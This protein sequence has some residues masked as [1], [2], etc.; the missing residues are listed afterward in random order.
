[1]HDDSSPQ[2]S[3]S[4]PAIDAIDMIRE[5]QAELTTVSEAM[6][7]PASDA[8]RFAQILDR[9]SEDLAEAAVL[10]RRA[11]ARETRFRP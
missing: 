5:T 3:P 6:P 1:V 4:N 11:A 2:P 8:E 9:L 10:V 7:A